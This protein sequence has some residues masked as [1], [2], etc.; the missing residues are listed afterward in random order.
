MKCCSSHR[1]V[2]FLHVTSLSSMLALRAWLGNSSGLAAA[3][4]CEREHSA[5]SQHPACPPHT[6]TWDCWE[7]A[8]KGD[9]PPHFSYLP[10]IYSSLK[11]YSHSHVCIDRVWGD[12]ARKGMQEL[13][14]QRLPRW[15][16]LHS[17]VQSSL[18]P[19]PL[20]TKLSHLP[21]DER[22]AKQ[23]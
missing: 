13:G 7:S 22:P 8:G 19:H 5:S 1:D 10:P 16:A 4:E 18:Q 23:S 12:T 17:V 15:D 14:A 2:I 20:H 21:L 11:S 9:L 6:A 3:V